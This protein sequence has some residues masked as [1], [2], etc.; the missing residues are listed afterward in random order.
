MERSPDVGDEIAER[1]KERTGI[2][3]CPRTNGRRQLLKEVCRQID[4]EKR[5]EH[6]RSN[7]LLGPLTL[8]VEQP[9]PNRRGQ[10]IACS[11]AQKLALW[12]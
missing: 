12:L 8:V 3:V 4:R 5:S 10:Q 1:S 11:A 6:I 2:D 7:S 9:E